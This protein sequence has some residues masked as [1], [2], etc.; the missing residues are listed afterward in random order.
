M[1]LSHYCI[2][3][4]CACVRAMVGKAYNTC[5]LVKVRWFQG[6]TFSTTPCYLCFET[7]ITFV[8][9]I[10]VSLAPHFFISLRKLKIFLLVKRRS[11]YHT[12]LNY[13]L[14]LDTLGANNK[15]IFNNYEYYFFKHICFKFECNCYKYLKIVSNIMKCI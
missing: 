5:S 6:T 3:D 7:I 2:R 1:I 4:M 15:Y 11:R 8:Y 9:D 12:L 13:K 14:F 10:L